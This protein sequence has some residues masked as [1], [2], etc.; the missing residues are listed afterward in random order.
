MSNCGKAAAG[1]LEKVAK[2]RDDPEWWLRSAASKVIKNVGPPHADRHA[3][4]MTRRF[5]REPYVY[6]KRRL[7]E[8][9][10]RLVE[11]GGKRKE[12]LAII[13]KDLAGQKSD[14]F[15]YIILEGLLKLGPKANAVLPAVEE[16]LN[17]ERQLLAKT[18]DAKQRTAG[19][20]SQT[21]R[22]LSPDVC[23]R[24]DMAGM[25]DL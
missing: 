3:E 1:Y 11:T 13:A 6:P 23:Y 22:R 2:F 24:T 9:M 19:M 8:M 21:L 16:L 4:A 5:V 14:Y 25:P 15:R 10:I 12:V 20:D 7:Q 17:K 18:K